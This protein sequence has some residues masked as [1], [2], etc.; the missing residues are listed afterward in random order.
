MIKESVPAAEALDRLKGGNKKYADKNAYHGDVSAPVRTAHM[1]GQLPYAVI[2]SCSD[3]RVIPESIFSAGIG[4]L[5]VIRVA[6]NGAAPSVLGSIQYAV[7]HLGVKLI[8][9]MGHENCGAVAAAL[10]GEEQGHVGA[11]ISDIKAAISEETD[12]DKACELNAR[13]AV[14]KICRELNLPDDVE[15]VPAIY[16]M[17]TGEAEFL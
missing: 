1:E 3:S 17:S 14:Q 4:E 10:K 15:V 12:A 9:V 7:S 8:V 5:F 6:G 16:K 13:A 11:L 2:L